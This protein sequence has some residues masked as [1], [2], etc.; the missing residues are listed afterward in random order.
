LAEADADGCLADPA[1]LG[2]ALAGLV[3]CTLGIEQFLV[4]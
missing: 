2:Q 3:C 4:Q 1:Q